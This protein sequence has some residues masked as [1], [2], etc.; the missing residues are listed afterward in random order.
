MRTITDNFGV[1]YDIIQPRKPRHSRERYT[2]DQAYDRP[3]QEKR[4]IYNWWVDYG[5]KNSTFKSFGIVAHNA[6]YF[7]LEGDYIDDKTGE[8]LGL[9]VITHCNHFIYLY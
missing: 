6:V 8:V 2:L 3:S 5:K 1:D 9:I 4:E 7:T